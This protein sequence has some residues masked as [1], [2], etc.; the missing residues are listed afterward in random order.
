[1]LQNDRFY[2]GAD[3]NAVQVLMLKD[4]A[5]D[6]FATRFTAPATHLAFNQSGSVLLA[7]ARSQIITSGVN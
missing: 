5:T 2:V 7:G 6:G 3:D 4:G 1:M